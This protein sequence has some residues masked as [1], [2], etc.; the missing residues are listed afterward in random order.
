MFLFELFRFGW[1]WLLSSLVASR[2]WFLFMTSSLIFVHV[3]VFR[4]S[5]LGFS[6]SL[7]CSGSRLRCCSSSS[8]CTSRR[9]WVWKSLGIF[10]FLNSIFPICRCGDNVWG[11]C[12]GAC[13][14]VGRSE[15][16]FYIYIEL[17]DCFYCFLLLLTVC[18]LF[19]IFLKKCP[20]LTEY[21]YLFIFFLFIFY[22]LF[23]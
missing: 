12:R 13:D 21:I 4:W 9:K 22:F 7:I 23:F 10:W 20:C 16:V 14:P 17:F 18:H 6:D 5:P 15:G 11:C 3:L 2:R 8:A 1:C 19:S